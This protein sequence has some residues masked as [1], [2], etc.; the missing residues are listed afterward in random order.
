MPLRKGQL[1]IINRSLNVRHYFFPAVLYPLTYKS[2]GC[3]E[4]LYLIL[5]IAT[6][7]ALSIAGGLVGRMSGG[8]ITDSVAANL[9]VEITQGIGRMGRIVGYISSSGTVTITNNFALDAM[10]AVG[11]S[12]DTDSAYY[13]IDKTEAQ[14]KDQSTYEGL[15]W[16]FGN[17]GE[18]IWKMPS[19]GGYPIVDWQ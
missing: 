3:Q 6:D 12:F 18:A 17:S 5:I 15:G 4:R 8:S 14:L 19:G 1:A 9:R 11:G 2:K 13:G 10:Q 7:S 16:Q